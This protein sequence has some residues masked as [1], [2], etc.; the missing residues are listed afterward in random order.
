MAVNEKTDSLVTKYARGNL[1]NTPEALL[2]FIQ[3]ELTRIEGFTNASTEA[4]IQ[5]TDKPVVNPKRGMVRYAVAPWYPVAS[6]LSGDTGLVVY[7]GSAWAVPMVST[8]W[9][10]VTVFENGWVNYHN[11]Y[12]NTAAY[13]KVGDIVYLKGLVKDGTV[14]STI[15]T[16][17]EGYR[18]P[19]SHL[20]NGTSSNGTYTRIDVDTDGHVEMRSGANGWC[21]L[22]GLSFSVI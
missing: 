18:P 11:T 19:K 15:F 6:V 7:D 14:D 21:S 8:P 20:F 3:S 2:Q 5:T 10:E 16:M 4:S 17:P 22:D 13:R 12:W 1:P 9:T